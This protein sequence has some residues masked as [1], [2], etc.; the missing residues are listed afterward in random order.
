MYLTREALETVEPITILGMHRSGTTMLVGL[1][2]EFGFFAGAKMGKNKESF[3]FQQWH[4]WLMRSSGGS[5]DYPTASCA[6]YG[7]DEIA[8]RYRN[9]VERQMRDSVIDWQFFR[10]AGFDRRRVHRGPWG[11]KEPRTMFF[12]RSWKRIFPRLKAVV[13]IRN[14]VD[15]ALSLHR[16]ARHAFGR[17]Y[18]DPFIHPWKLRLAN[19]IQHRPQYVLGS[20]RCLDLRES[21]RLWEEYMERMQDVAQSFTAEEVL[22]F[23]YEDLLL[24]PEPLLRR[25]LDFCGIR[26]SEREARRLAGVINR[27][28]AYGFIG[29]ERGEDLYQAVRGRALMLEYDYGQVG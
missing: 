3:F 8:G 2:Q 10:F 16:R 13:I 29:D 12:A 26:V 24:D 28:R 7:D 21:Y 14:G 19:L 25:V 17:P 9:R 11:W 5:W 18:A 23:R 15:V 6:L 22:V 1:M 20:L 4:E 27:R